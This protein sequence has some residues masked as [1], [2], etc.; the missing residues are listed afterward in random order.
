MAK[1]EFTKYWD[2]L[3]ARATHRLAGQAPKIPA[4]VTPELR[5]ALSELEVHGVELELQ[6]EE[7]RRIQR[8]MLIVQRELE[9]SRESYK[10]L[11][12]YAP[13]AY[14]TLDRTGY[15]ERCNQSAARLLGI[16]ADA[17]AGTHFGHFLSPADV[18]RFH[19]LLRGFFNSADRDTTE[20]MQLVLEDQPAVDTL[21]GIRVVRDPSGEPE[22]FRLTLQDITEHKRIQAQMLDIQKLDSIGTL[23]A[24]VAHDFNN[25]LASILGRS[26]I[27]ESLETDEAKLRHITS[28]TK[29]S[30]RAAEL[31]G[32]LLAAGRKGRSEHGAVD[33]NAIVQEVFTLLESLG[34]QNVLLESKEDPELGTV[35][36]DASQVYQAVLNVCINAVE[37]IGRAGSVRA[38]TRNVVVESGEFPELRAGTYSV[39][40]VTDTG[41]GMDEAT[42]RRIFEPF[43]TTKEH[44]DVKGTGLGLAVTYGVVRSHGGTL[45]VSSEPG[46]GSSFELYFPRGKLVSGAEQRTAPPRADGTGLILCVEDNAAFLRALGEMLGLLGYETMAASD[47]REAIEIYEAQR[48]QISLV[49]LDIKMPGI[50]GLETFLAIKRINPDARVVISTGFGENREVQQMLERGAL[51]ILQ[52]PYSLRE[53]ESLLRSVLA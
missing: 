47:G 10:D 25:V 27:L 21:L 11:Y 5:E 49:V 9:D 53:L 39:L 2:D 34:K 41:I 37:S 51:A 20:E 1:E 7:L 3:R 4:G 46:V 15:I 30:E 50:G 45:K 12:E 40:E 28:I 13:I 36:G 38:R 6:N 14:L 18:D 32:K 48:A 29:A 17:A 8:D 43:F 52:K 42:L 44:R 33:I 35:D 23:A 19:L 16:S 26:S 24:G 22:S 31:T